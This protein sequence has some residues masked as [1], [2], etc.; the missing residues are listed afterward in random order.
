[1]IEA[2]MSYLGPSH[3]VTWSNHWGPAAELWL[4]NND[5]FDTRRD[6]HPWKKLNWDHHQCKNDHQSRP[7][8]LIQFLSPSSSLRSS[9]F[10]G[11]ARAGCS[12]RPNRGSLG[13]G[14]EGGSGAVS[15]AGSGAG[16]GSSVSKMLISP[17]WVYLCFIT[18]FSLNNI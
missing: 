16:S 9:L 3:K 2:E 6:D 11:L 7:D 13:A 15:G 8:S 5:W 10:S 1:M 4:G 14:S 12:H 18:L 17:V